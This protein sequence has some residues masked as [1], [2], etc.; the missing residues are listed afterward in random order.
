MEIH[1]VR[2]GETEWSASG[3]HTSVTDLDLTE[4]GVAQATALRER[5]AA[6]P[7]GL[8]LC[9][10]RL[11]AR[12]TASLAGFD[13]PVITDDLQEWRYGDYEGLT[14][15]QI[16]EHDPGWTIWTHPTP[17]GESAAQVT[18][19][20]SRLITRIR[21]SGVERALCFAHGHSLRALALTWL[22]VDLRHGDQFPLHTATLSVL[23]DDKDQQAL[24]S[25]NA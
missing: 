23:G 22:G 5:L 12:R 18:A 11:R 17:G 16:R 2:H 24:I 13:E 14:S 6:T 1:L 21:E 9:S 25:W 15:E 7:Y 20:L 3:R 4:R 8:V 19:R 10:P